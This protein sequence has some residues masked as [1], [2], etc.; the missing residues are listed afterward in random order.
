[1]K[2]YTARWRDGAE[3]KAVPWQSGWN[4]PDMARLIDRIYAEGKKPKVYVWNG[5]DW[6]IHPCPSAN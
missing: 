6:M 4:M 5:A 1:M 3:T 2:L